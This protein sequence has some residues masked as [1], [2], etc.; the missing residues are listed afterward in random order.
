VKGRASLAAIAWRISVD[1]NRTLGGGMASIEL[2]RRS[3]EKR[4]WLDESGHALLVAVS[5]FTPGTNLLA[6]CVGLGWLVHRGAGAALALAGASIPGAVVV[7]A[8]SAVIARLVA[9][10]MVRAGLAVA[11]LVAAALVLSSAWALMR[12]HV[13][14]SRRVWALSVAVAAAALFASG[15]SPIRV[16]LIAAVLGALSPPREDVG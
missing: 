4:G 16:L 2:I 13:F 5:R 10:P 14:G 15:L 12:P 6:Y 11:T 1:A 3:F 9:W 7:T 8:F